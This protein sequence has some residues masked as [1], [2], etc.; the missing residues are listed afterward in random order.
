MKITNEFRGLWKLTVAGQR[1]RF[2]PTQA[3]A[4]AVANRWTRHLG[5]MA[6]AELGKPHND[7]VLRSA[8][9]EGLYAK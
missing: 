7:A 8:L 5:C 6:P 4:A 2:Y 1:A 9:D 3:E